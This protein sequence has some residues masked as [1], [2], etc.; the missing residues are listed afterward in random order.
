MRPART[1]RLALGFALSSLSLYAATLTVTTA[2]DSGAGSLRDAITQSNASAGTLDT[3]AFAI[4]GAGVHTIALDT[5]LPIVTDPVVIDG[6][7][8]PGYAGAPLIELTPNTPIG[9]FRID[10]GGTTIRGLNIHGFGTNLQFFTNGGNVIEACY[11]GTDPTGTTGSAGTG[12]A[13]QNSGNNRIGGPTV[14]SHN[15]ISGMNGN[16]ITLIG[17]DGTVIQGNLI[18]SDASGA[19]ALGNGSGIS[20]V[21]STDVTIGGTVAGLGNLVSS[22]SGD[23][24]HVTNSG[25]VLIA[26]NLVGTDLSGTLARPNNFGFDV[27]NLTGSITIGGLETAARNI[28]SGNNLGIFLNNGVHG[29]TIQGN[30]IGTDITGT[31]PLPNTVG[32]LTNTL[33]TTDLVIGGPGPG[34]GNVIAFNRGVGNSHGIWN[35]GLRVTMRGNSIHDNDGIGIDNGLAGPDPNDPGDADAGPNDGQNFPL[36]SSVQILGPQGTGTRVT[37]VLRSLPSATYTL[38]FYGNTGCTPRPQDFV[39]GETYLGNSQ[40]TTDGTGSATFDVTLPVAIAP[41]DFVSAT[42]TDPGGS[43]SEFSQRLPF[44]VFPT[45]G[46]ASGGTALT[47]QGTDFSAGAAVTIGGQPAAGVN[48]E[49]STQITAQS[50]LLAAGTVNDLTVTNTDLTNGTL[51]KA[52]VADF[53]DAPAFHQFHSYVTILVRNAITA[54]VG[55][56]LYGVDQPTLRQQMA[57]FLLKARYGVCYVPPPCGGT[58]S[59]VPCPS[60]FANWIEDLAAQGITGGCGTGVYCPQN[61]VRRDQM[62]VF[63]LKAEHG[64]SYAPPACSGTFPDVPCP[65]TFADWIEQLSAENI[66]GGCG[67]GNYCPGNPN[68]RG[69]MAVFITKTFNLQ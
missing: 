59:D 18:G 11:I 37:G 7:T 21:N 12:I 46:P 52:W 5:S 68:T 56:G 51:P 47:I 24:I 20:V 30:F 57:V 17:S 40:A 50:P 62:A 63:L 55:G 35:L 38:D 54:G 58:F 67:G 48:I 31:L 19:G 10:A 23:G 16:G 3:I 33:D 2:A 64:S 44:S 53:L 29:G 26:G 27:N 39:E 6:T 9:S 36:I 34:E 69:Q 22:N 60:T 25:N 45:S 49:S 1:A 14:A 13:M 65:S 8:Q 42:A 66:T 28:V 61:P 43:T 41:G 15:L 4:A 32:I